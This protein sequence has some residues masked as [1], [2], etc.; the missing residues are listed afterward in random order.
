RL[1]IFPH[2]QANGIRQLFPCWDEPHLK[3]TFTISIK[4]Y[5][6]FITLSN[7]PIK[8]HSTNYNLSKDN[9]IWT[10]F[11]TTPPMSTLQITIVMMTKRHSNKINENITLWCDCNIEHPSLEFTREIINNITFHLKS[12]FCEIN[13][14]KMDH[15][16]IPNF[17]Q[18]GI[19]KWGI[20]FH[21]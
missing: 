14:P 6:N 10:H 16:I 12:E 5:R 11:Y 18:D 13:I 1:V 21:T 2:I 4:H 17:P 20:I 7:M 15:I 8:E 9:E 19:S 3:T